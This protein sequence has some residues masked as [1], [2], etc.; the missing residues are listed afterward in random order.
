MYSVVV[1]DFPL[2]SEEAE[3]SQKMSITRDLAVPFLGNYPR[4][5][6]DVSTQRCV[7]L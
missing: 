5:M 4:G 1:V 3:I 2:T 7:C 6:K